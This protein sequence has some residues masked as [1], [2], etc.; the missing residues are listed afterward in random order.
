MKKC[1]PTRAKSGRRAIRPAA[2]C[3]IKVERWLWQPNPPC[4]QFAFEARGVAPKY[5]A[6]HAGVQGALDVDAQIIDEYTL[7]GVEPKLIA[8][9]TINGHLRLEQVPVSGDEQPVKTVVPGKFGA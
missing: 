3:N 5:N 8:E 1:N 6:I 2:A 9:G 7:C 4:G